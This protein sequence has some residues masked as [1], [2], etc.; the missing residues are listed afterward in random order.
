[1]TWMQLRRV[2]TLDAAA[3][4][5]AEAAKERAT[6]SGMEEEEQQEEGDV[7]VPSKGH[8]GP[9]YNHA[10]ASVERKM[11]K[12]RWECAPPIALFSP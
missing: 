6:G 3:H 10:D 9:W 1:V 2:A 5:E 8:R 4:E 12:F 7:P 11:G